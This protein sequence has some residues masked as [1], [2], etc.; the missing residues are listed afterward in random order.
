MCLTES[1]MQILHV[2]DREEYKRFENDKPKIINLIEKIR[3]HIR[4]PTKES[5]KQ[6]LRENRLMK[7]YEY[8]NKDGPQYIEINWEKIW[9]YGKNIDMITKVYSFW[10]KHVPHTQFYCV[11]PRSFALGLLT[12]AKDGPKALLSMQCK[13]RREQT[14]KEYI[15]IGFVTQQS[16]RCI[17]RSWRR[18]VLTRNLK[19]SIIQGAWRECISN[20][21]H[22]VCRKRLHREFADISDPL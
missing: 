15:L 11:N 4:S 12:L 5:I 7:Y 18:Y 20:P 19:A 16:A 6:Y 9:D 1:S 21:R 17:Q 14:I 2:Y 10:W 3:Q 8:L 22:F 13:N